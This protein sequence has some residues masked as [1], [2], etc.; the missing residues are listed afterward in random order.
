MLRLAEKK[1][2]QE[3][4]ENVR[5]EDAGNKIYQYYKLLPCSVSVELMIATFSELLEVCRPTPSKYIIGKCQSR[6]FWTTH[7]ITVTQ[8]QATRAM[9][10]LS[11]KKN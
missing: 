10:N 7:A 9:Q 8:R 4:R 11:Q 3:H 1:R 2:M 6:K 5:D